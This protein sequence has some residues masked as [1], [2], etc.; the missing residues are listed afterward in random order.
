MAAVTKTSLEMSSVLYCG[1]PVFSHFS[2][3]Q[4]SVLFIIYIFSLMI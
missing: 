2:P 1:V 3:D 4:D